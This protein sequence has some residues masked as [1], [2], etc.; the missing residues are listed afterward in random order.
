MQ[1]IGQCKLY[2]GDCLQ[3]LPEAVLSES[4]DLNLT[5][6]PYGTTQCKWD[7]P[8]DL[9]A[10]WV[11]VKRIRK[12]R[13][14]TVLF[15]TQPF[16]SILVTSNLD[17]FKYCW[18]WDKV[19]AKG[20]LVAKIRPLQ[21]T[22]QI[23]VF[24]KDRINYYPIMVPRKKPRFQTSGPIPECMGGGESGYKSR[25]AYARYPKTLLQFSWSGK[26]KF[27]P[28]Q[29]PTP[30]LEYLIKTYT[31]EGDLVIDFT[32]GSGSTGEACIKLS[33]RFVGI[34][35]KEEYYNTACSRLEKAWLEKKS[36]LF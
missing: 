12:D 10:F 19:T 33:R 17:E 24:G 25:W 8:I 28:T 13:S 14:A 27:H 20:H 16:T 21:Q 34:E 35:L 3:L 7:T 31:K 4:V 29:K 18:D 15:C 26:N 9:D 23:A 30:L 36:E 22:E 2:Q 1:Q 11:E 6:L 5:D 32:M